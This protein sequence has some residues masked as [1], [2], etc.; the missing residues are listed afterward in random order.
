MP[1]TKQNYPDSMKNLMAPV[2]NK[3]IDIANALLRDGREEGSA[4]AIATAQAEKWA[5]ERGMKVKKT[6]KS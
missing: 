6:R 5:G 1:W 4:I 3:A 2:R